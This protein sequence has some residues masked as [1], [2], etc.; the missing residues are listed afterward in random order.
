[1]PKTEPKTLYICE[2]HE[3]DKGSAR[4]LVAIRPPVRAEALAH[5]ACAAV[6]LRAALAGKIP[7]T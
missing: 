7:P 3:P 1:M 5:P 2:E 6:L 4:V